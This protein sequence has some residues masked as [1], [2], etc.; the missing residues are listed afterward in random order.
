MVENKMMVQDLF[1]KQ[2][3]L[4]EANESKYRAIEKLKRERLKNIIEIDNIANRLR[5]F[6][7]RDKIKKW[8]ETR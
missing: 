5:V 6:F 2:A 3:D 8:S 4:Q 1:N 7:G